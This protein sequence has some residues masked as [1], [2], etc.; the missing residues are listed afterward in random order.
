MEVALRARHHVLRR[1]AGLLWIVA[2]AVLPAVYLLWRLAPDV[3]SKPLFI[4]ESLAG[5]VAARPLGE[6]VSVVLWD[7]GGSPGHFVFSHVAIAFDPSF[8]ALRW[9]SVAFAL[10]AIPVTYDLGRRLAGPPAGLVAAFVLASSSML[11]V[12]GSFGRMYALFAFASALAADLFV[13]ALQERTVPAATA[14]AVGAW[15]LP[16][17]HPYGAIVLAVEAAVALVVW[18]GRPLRGAIPAVLVGVALLPFVIADLKLRDRFSVGI[19]GKS[20]LQTP[21]KAIDLVEGVLG[22]AAG[23]RGALFFLFLTLGLVGL[24]LLAPR[25][26]AFVAFAVLATL[27]PPALLVLGRAG[28]EGGLAHLSTRHL[29]YV[30]PLWAA[31]IG[32]AVA[33]AAARFG[34]L[35]AVA[36]ALAV[37]VV[38]IVAPPRTGDPRF[39]AD[40]RPGVLREPAAWLE[41]RIDEDAVLFPVSPVYLAALPAARQGISISRRDSPLDTLE[42]EDFPAPEIVVAVPTTRSVVDAAALRGALP[43]NAEIG[44]FPRWVLIAR[45]GSYTGSE[46]TLRALVETLRAAS[47]ATT[48]QAGSLRTYYRGSISLLCVSLRRLGSPCTPEGR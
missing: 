31:V 2:G 35:A 3:G 29:I 10:A 23:G 15:L 39:A 4:D 30:L 43:A 21:G 14:A 7:R 9:L 38:A 6:V 48:K 26:P 16:A 44:I 24:A 28:G 27:A 37:V 18:R 41:E 19:H 5:L 46:A 8:Q 34:P 45:P 47:G 36:A 25:E 20:S 40:A 17:V 13:R 11:G 33:L 22:G 12:Y 1:R 42:H 32:A